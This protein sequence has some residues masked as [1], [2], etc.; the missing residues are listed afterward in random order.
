MRAAAARDC[1]QLAPNRRLGSRGIRLVQRVVRAIGLRRGVGMAMMAE[2]RRRAGLHRRRALPPAVPLTVQSRRLVSF[3][4][5]HA[6]IDEIRR[7]R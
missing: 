3:R 4:R 6:R 5:L 1:R 2:P 7:A